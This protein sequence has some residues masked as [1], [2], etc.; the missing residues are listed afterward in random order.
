MT[1]E[2][3][4]NIITELDVKTLNILTSKKSDYAENTDVLSNFKIVSE[5][6]NLLKLLPSNSTNYALFMVILKLARIG[7]LLESGKT[8]QNESLADSFE[9]GINY[10]KLALCCLKEESK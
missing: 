7:N 8:P 10:F 3:Q 4:F 5:V 9:D 1:S 6:A 2:Q